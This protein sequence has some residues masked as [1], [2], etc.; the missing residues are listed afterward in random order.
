MNGNYFIAY[1]AI[2]DKYFTCAFYCQLTIKNTLYKANVLLKF[3]IK[4]WFHEWK[5]SLQQGTNTGYAQEQED[6]ITLPETSKRGLHSFGKIFLGTDET[7]MNLYQN[8]GRETG[9]DLKHATS[10]VNML[11][12]H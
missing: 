10:S 3:T 12:Q 7:R 5:Y 8:D 9:N 6:Q 1:C 11:C 4:R 2:T